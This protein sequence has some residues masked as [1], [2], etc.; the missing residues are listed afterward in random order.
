MATEIE[1]LLEVAVLGRTVGL[2]GGL[3]LHNRSDFIKQ[4]KK[5]AKFCL[6]DGKELVISSF[7]AASGVVVFEGFG[8][9]EAAKTL[10]NQTLFCTISQ[11]KKYCKLSSGEYFYFDIIG[12]TI[13]ENG[14]VLGVVDDILEVGGGFLF[15]VKSPKSLVDSGLAKSFFIPYNDHFCEQIDLCGGTISVKN[16]RAILENS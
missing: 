14:E 10:V 6:K 5:G 13:I 12:L 8:S 3:K 11:T 1:R 4:F 16:A 7:N 15:E 2:N 9:I